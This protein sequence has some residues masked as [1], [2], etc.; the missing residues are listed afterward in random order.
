LWYYE[1]AFFGPVGGRMTTPLSDLR[2][3]EWGIAAA[4]SIM[5][6]WIGL[7]PAPFLNMINPSVQKLAE[8]LEQGSVTKAVHFERVGK[9]GEAR[10]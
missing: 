9:G 6:F 4:L 3:R 1:R 2:P 7:Y 8:R 10:P 5:I